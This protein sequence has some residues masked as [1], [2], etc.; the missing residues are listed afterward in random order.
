MQ[1]HA[2]LEYGV[3]LCGDD[4]PIRSRSVGIAASGIATILKHT[5][6]GF[7]PA[8]VM[9]PYIPHWGRPSNEYVSIW[10][11]RPSGKDVMIPATARW[12]LTG[13]QQHHIPRTI[14]KHTGDSISGPQT[15][16][17]G[18]HNVLEYGAQKNLGCIPICC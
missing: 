3:I 11:R 4:I 15:P 9:T 10:S 7:E 5:R 12:S 17:T 18:S 13:C 16:A 2:V 14:V 8:R 6:T 1:S